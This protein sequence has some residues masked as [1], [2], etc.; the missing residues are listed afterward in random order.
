[1]PDRARA[2]R[3]RDLVPR[4][5]QPIRIAGALDRLTEEIAPA[6]ALGSLQAVWRSAVGDRI[7]DACQPT[8]ESEGVLTVVCE[9]SVWAQQL[10]LMQTDLLERL[11]AELPE[12]TK[13]PAELRFTVSGSQA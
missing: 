8:Q 7:A 3:Q 11:E 10:A 2:Q 12:G 1:M 4:R 5:K 6:T 9:S 13:P